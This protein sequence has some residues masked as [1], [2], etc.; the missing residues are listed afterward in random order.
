MGF[1]DRLLGRTPQDE[2]TPRRHATYAGHESPVYGTP[3]PA[4]TG[5]GRS[6]DDVAI[7]RYRYLLRTAPPEAVEQAHAEAFERLTPEQR[8]RVLTDLGENLPPAERATADD[9]RS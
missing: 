8:R 9:P 6:E 5:P 7:D 3:P 4:P 1:L 2:G